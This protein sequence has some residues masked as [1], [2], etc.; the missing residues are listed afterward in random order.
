MRIREYIQVRETGII[1]ETLID[2][3]A[4]QFVIE[5]DEGQ[6]FIMPTIN[7]YTYYSYLGTYTNSGTCVYDYNVDWGDGSVVENITTYLDTKHTYVEAGSY[8]ITVRSTTK[9]FPTFDLSNSTYTAMRPYITRVVSWGDV[10]LHKCSFYGATALVALPD[11]KAKL[12]S[13]VTANNMF[14]QCSA[15]TLVPLGLFYATV[16]GGEDHIYI[17]DFTNVFAYCSKLRNIDETI[18]LDAIGALNFSYAFRYCIRLLSL[19][20]N[21]FSTTPLVT[22]FYYTFAYCETL[23]ELPATLFNATT[24]VSNFS[25][26]F[27][28]C[29]GL[30]S[31][32]ASLFDTVTVN[33]CSFN[34]T[35]YYCTALT[36]VPYG[37]FT[38]VKSSTFYNTFYYCSSLATI[39][40]DLFKGQRYCTSF[41]RCF[42]YCRK[43]TGVPTGVFDIDVTGY[44]NVCVDMNYCFS[45]SGTDISVIS[46]TVVA[47]LFDQLT[48]VTNFSNVFSGCTKFSNIPAGFLDNCVAATTFYF[49]FYNNA[50]VS[51]PNNLFS[52][53]VDATDFRGVFRSNG[54]LTSAGLPGNIFSGCIS[55]K[56]FGYEQYYGYGAFGYCDNVAF[57]YIPAGLF[58]SCINAEDFSGVFYNCSHLDTIP[59]DLFRYNTT[60]ISFEY[61]FSNTAITATNSNLFQYN[62][63]VTNMRYVFSGCSLLTTIDAD[64]FNTYNNTPNAI[65][66]FS[67]TFSGCTLI[68]AIPATLFQY[69]INAKYFTKT[70]RNTGITVIPDYL[71]LNNTIIETLD[72]CFSATLITA[73]PATLFDALTQVNSVAYCF[74]Y[75]HELLSIPA[76]LFDDIGLSRTVSFASCFR[77]QSTDA[78]YNKITGAVPELWTTPN[79]PDGTQCFL[80]RTAISNYAS[81]PAGWK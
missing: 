15:L 31:L 27:A 69:S 23:T 25:Y 44:S 37:L 28:N 48:H 42:Y 50:H 30:I 51:I 56:L 12:V 20:A 39:P 57:T 16:A 7:T 79:N 6:E 76:G 49:A 5:V 34:S 32:P 41:A 66:D 21:L 2:P 46:F 26:T 1:P 68:T 36:A 81:I 65:V 24:Q 17:S 74:Y 71:F 9:K 61:A 33:T 75:C 19:P 63:S 73:I 40:I 80:N 35:F 72:S 64:T 55:A 47:G 18:F 45:S 29:I 78:A 14:Y 3:D 70:L 59:T 52:N 11:Q 67:G 62:R 8:L 38:N 58:D 43:L 60:A 22:N 4:F 54:E 53:C 77:V 10:G 13:L